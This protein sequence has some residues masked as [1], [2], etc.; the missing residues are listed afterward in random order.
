MFF[1]HLCFDWVAYSKMLFK[2]SQY[3]NHIKLL[4]NKILIVFH[5]QELNK[6]LSS[7]LHDPAEL[8]LHPLF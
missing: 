1:R 6:V 5:K 2:S 7:L 8:S 4:E 3:G